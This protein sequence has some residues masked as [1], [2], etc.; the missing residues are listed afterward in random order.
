MARIPSAIL[1]LA[2]IVFGLS[3][4]DYVVPSRGISADI[5]AAM[6]GGPTSINPGRTLDQRDEPEGSVPWHP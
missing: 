4:C 3:A 2:V 1:M 5:D 6:W